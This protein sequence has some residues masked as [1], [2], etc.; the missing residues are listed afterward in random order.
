AKGV[1]RHKISRRNGILRDIFSSTYIFVVSI[2]YLLELRWCASVLT[3][4]AR[5][6]SAVLRSLPLST[7][8]KSVLQSAHI[9]TTRRTECTNFILRDWI[10]RWPSSLCWC[11]YWRP[12][13]CRGSERAG[14]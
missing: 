6:L 13:A 14:R 12:M 2:F 9:Y 1:Q 10:A 5:Q 11:W 3:A 4:F 8:A 7:Q